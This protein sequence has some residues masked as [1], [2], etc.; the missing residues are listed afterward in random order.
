MRYAGRIQ[1]WNDE[2]GYGFVVPNGGGERSFVHIKSFQRGS[3]RPLDG[4]L[5]SYAVA[6]DGR[7]RSNAVQVR[8]DGQAAAP[9]RRVNRKP[10][11]I[12]RRSIGIAALATVLATWLAGWLPVSLAIAYLVA[13]GVSYLLYFSDKSAAGRRH[14]RRTPENTLH[15]VDLLGGWPG[16]LLAQHAYRHKT[17]KASFQATF[18]TTVVLNIAVVAWLVGSGR[19]A[20]LTD[21]LGG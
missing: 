7:G 20:S 5:V 6:R 2:K 16:A 9:A 8:F 17:V 13:S 18:W 10:L 14:L 19:F 1:G 15:L 4:D 3:R 12:P 21:A 11:P